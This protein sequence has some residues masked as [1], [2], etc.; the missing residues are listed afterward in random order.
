MPQLVGLPCSICGERIGS[1]LDAAFCSACEYPVHNRC[2]LPTTSARPTVCTGCGC[3][4]S[5][6][7]RREQEREVE[8]QRRIATLP[9]PPSQM[10]EVKQLS[11]VWNVARFLIGGFFVAM[12]GVF[13]L[14]EGEPVGLGAIGAG[15]VV[16]AVGVFGAY[17][18]LR[19]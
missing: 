14:I 15:L 6:A 3:D 7:A 8:R 13:L 4:L 17:R 2:K 10:A 19:E 12:F 16:A 18:I 5:L 11:A 9:P 1:V